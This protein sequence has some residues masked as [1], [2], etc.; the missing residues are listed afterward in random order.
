MPRLALANRVT[1]VT[2]SMTLAISAR[3]KAMKTEGL[4]VC[5]FSAGEP[6]FDTPDHIKAAAKDALDAGKTRYGPA[7]GEPALRQAIANKLQHDNSL[8]YGPENVI[9]TNGGKHSLYGLMMALIEPGD[10]VIIPAPYWLSYPEMVKLAGGTP[11]IVPTTA[12]Q[13]YRITPEQLRQAITPQTKL[14]ILNSPSNPTGMVYSPAEIAA[15]AAVVVE[16]DIWVVSDEIYEKILYDEATHLSIGAV[17]P[18][19][20]EHTI[21][22]NGFAKAYSMTGWRV[23]YLAGPAELIK[24]VATVQGHSTSNVCTFAQYGAIA[25]LEGPQDCIATMGHAFA[26]RRQAIID[27]CRA[28]DSLSCGEPEGAFYL[29]IDISALGIPSLDF[30]TQL[31]DEKYVAAIPGIAFGAEGTIR[32]SYA[33]DMETILEGMDRLEAFVAG[34][35]G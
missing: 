18:E 34:R 21:I 10:E 27:R 3:A 8:C 32:I 16:A 14:F 30:C 17:S 12:E 20:F 23:G 4:P 25:A 28:I 6:D 35:L 7:A 9:V 13:N 26:K 29:Y 5:S 33:T 11:V 2:P 15:L 22:S 1:C 31:L 24:A 19:A